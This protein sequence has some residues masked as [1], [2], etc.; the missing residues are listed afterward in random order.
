M[1]IIKYLKELLKDKTH[2]YSLRE[3]VIAISM[4]LIVVSWF[5]QILF[6]KSTPE[7]MFYSI[8]SLVAAGCFGYSIEKPKPND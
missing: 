6:N 4:I 1:N 7:F 5:A 8:V 3:F 2:N